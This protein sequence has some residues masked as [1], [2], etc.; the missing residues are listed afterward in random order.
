MPEQSADP[1]PCDLAEAFDNAVGLY[2]IWKWGPS[3]PERKVI[4][5]GQHLSMSEVCGLVDQ[6]TDRLPDQVFVNLRSCMHHYPHG[7]LIA[8]LEA[9]QSY[10]TGARCLRRMIEMSVEG[11]RK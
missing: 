9:D 5:N 10:A 3:Q 4:Y 1:I 8:D 11:L 7:Q 2:E 6:F